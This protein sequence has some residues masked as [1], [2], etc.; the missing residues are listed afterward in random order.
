MRIETIGSATLYLGDCLEILPTLPKVDAV[1][2]DPPYDNKTHEGA[3]LNGSIDF[4]PLPSVSVIVP[5][6]LDTCDKWC[7][8]FCSLE[9][10]AAYRDAAGDAWI[11]AG[12]WDR[13]SNMPQMSG[14]RPA[15]AVEGV[16]IFHKPGRKRWNGGGKAAL[17]RHP[18]ERGEKEHPTQKPVLLMRE[19]VGMFTNHGDSILDPFMGSGSTGVAATPLG[20]SFVGIEREP[21]YF[22]IACRRIENSQRQTSLLDGY[23]QTTRL[24]GQHGLFTTGPHG[25]TA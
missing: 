12:A 3:R 4:A 11:R 21:K 10:L 6:L 23:E 25:E 17:W 20:R 16:A 8:C 13:I 1:I 22:D 2:T 18:V 7:I 14:D 9:M 24:D 19:L 5:S 15:Q